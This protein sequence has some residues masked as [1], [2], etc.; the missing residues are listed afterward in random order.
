MREGIRSKRLSIQA[1]SHP[2]ILT[3]AQ[4][5]DIVRDALQNHSG[6]YR[7]RKTHGEANRRLP[8]AYDPQFRGSMKQHFES[9]GL[10]AAE[11]IRSWH[12]PGAMLVGR[13]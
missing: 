12:S 8:G 11:T 6:G 4:K 2:P 1:G 3:R 5:D 7:L 13:S 10:V 9:F